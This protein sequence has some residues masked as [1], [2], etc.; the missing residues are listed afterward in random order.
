M[1][2][3]L[4]I[5]DNELNSDMLTRRL[6]RRG[7][8]VI[9]AFDGAQGLALVNAE[10]PDLILM[11]MRLPDIS[12]WELT[13]Q[14]KHDPITCNIP[15]IAVTAHAMETHRQQAMD[16]GCDDYDTKPVEFDRLLGKIYRL[17]KMEVPL[18]TD[19]R[20]VG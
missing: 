2:T 13:S 18:T 9:S 4:V 10:R 3:I 15:V 20:K 5:E 14:I 16:S 8:R 1:M 19:V 7:F 11:D 12:G 17:L 6:T